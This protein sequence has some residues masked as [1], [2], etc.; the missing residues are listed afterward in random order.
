MCVIFGDNGVVVCGSLG[1]RDGGDWVWEHREVCNLGGVVD[2]NDVV[3]GA[4]DN[5]DAIFILFRDV[6]E[7][8]EVLV[9]V[10]L[11]DLEGVSLLGDDPS[12]GD[13]VLAGFSHDDHV[14]RHGPWREYVDFPKEAGP[15]R[16][17][18]DLRLSVV[19]ELWRTDVIVRPELDDGPLWDEDD[20]RFNV[21]W[22]IGSP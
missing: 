9:E 7:R 22:V 5:N 12:S 20:F 3:G 8:D 13:P 14:F 1:S 16:H 19:D 4:V 11:T 17:G 15:I 18:E 6:I 21:S 2:D 10:S